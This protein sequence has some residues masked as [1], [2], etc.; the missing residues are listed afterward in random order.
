MVSSSL[1]VSLALTA[2]VQAH[3]WLDCTN[4]QMFQGERVTKFDAAK[5]LG[6]ARCGTT[7]AKAG[8]GMDTGF[9]HHDKTCQCARNADNAYS[10]QAPMAQY[11]P[12]QRVCL[13]YPAKNHVAET[14]TN[15]Y[16]PDNGVRILRSAGPVNMRDGTDSF[17]REYNHLNGKHTNGQIDYKGFQNCPDF[18]SNMDKAVCTMCFDLEADIAPGTYSFQWQWQFNTGDFYSTCWEAT[19]AGSAVSTPVAA[20]TKVTTSTPYQ[21][22]ATT[23]TTPPPYQAAAPVSNAPRPS[24]AAPQEPC[25]TL[26]PKC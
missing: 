1:L 8:F 19:I 21:A 3:S 7:Q 5:C 14:C 20:V 4:Y 18:C 26:H 16:I 9:N 2:T 10:T 15:A 17:S 11:R 6:Y 13:A 24:A 12:G 25:P 22:A 23:T